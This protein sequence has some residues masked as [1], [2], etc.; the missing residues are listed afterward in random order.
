MRKVRPLL[1]A[2]G[3]VAAAVLAITV[4]ACSSGRHVTAGPLGPAGNQDSECIPGK[5]GVPDT[6][7]GELLRN[8]SNATISIDRIELNGTRHMTLTRAFLAPGNVGIVAAIGFPPPVSQVNESNWRERATAPGYHVPPHHVV[9]VIVGLERSAAVG[10]TNGVEVAYHQGRNHYLLKTNWKV[11][12][13]AK[14]F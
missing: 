8:G 14:C 11:T 3:P 12:I 1:L 13:K 9:N 6:F 7:G 5:A 10:S 2:V 4:V